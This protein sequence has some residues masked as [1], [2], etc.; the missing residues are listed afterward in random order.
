M[1]PVENS[2]RLT[3]LLG[4]RTKEEI[5][6]RPAAEAAGA[7]EAVAAGEAVEEA[8]VEVAHRTN[9]E[10]CWPSP[11]ISAPTNRNSR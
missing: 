11:E 8:A 1:Q 2:K 6:G 10:R 7:E 5:M 9:S 4:E 3:D